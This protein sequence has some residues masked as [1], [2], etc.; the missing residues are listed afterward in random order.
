[1]RIRGRVLLA[2]GTPLRDAEVHFEINQRSADGRHTGSNSGPKNLDADGY[3]VEYV[4]EPA[5]YTVTVVY[6]GQFAESEKILLEDGQRL[7]RL[8]LTLSDDPGEQL[9][10]KVVVKPVFKPVVLASPKQVVKPKILIPPRSPNPQSAETARKREREGMWAINPDNRHAYK[11]I[12]CETHQEAQAKASAQGA[13]L[14]TINDA[15]EQKWLLEI[16][17]RDSLWIEQTKQAWNFK[18]FGQQGFWIGL[19]DGAKEGDLQ[20]DNGEPVDYTN[21][22]SPQKIVEGDDHTQHGDAIQN[23]TVFVGI[24]GK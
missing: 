9:P 13:H 17:G 18:T 8:A 21:W 7:D 24:T 14:V 19:T 2:D 15:A 22:G 4:E 3:F 1:M 11:R 5:F 6:Q 20:W 10:S 23:Y 12:Y 16:F